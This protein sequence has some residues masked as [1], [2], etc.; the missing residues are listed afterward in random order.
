M[1]KT[2]RRSALMKLPGRIMAEGIALRLYFA[3]GI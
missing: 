2:R 1:K 3:A